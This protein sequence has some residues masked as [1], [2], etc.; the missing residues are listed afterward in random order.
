MKKFT[1]PAISGAE[2][3]IGSNSPGP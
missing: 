2:P 1:C 3:W